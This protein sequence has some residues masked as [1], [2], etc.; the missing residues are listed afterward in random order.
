MRKISIM[1]LLIGTFLFFSVPIASESFYQDPETSQDLLDEI[2]K[3]C[4]EYCEKLTQSVLDFVCRESITEEISTVDYRQREITGDSAGKTSIMSS[5]WKKGN[6]LNTFIYDYQMI[7]KDNII[8]DRR[9]LIRENGIKKYEVNAEPRIKRFKHHNILFGPIALL[10]L[11]WQPFYDYKIIQ[12]EKFRREN[13]VVIEAIPK[14]TNT[15]ENPFGKGWVR[16]DDYSIIKIEW[17]QKSLPNLG[18][19]EKD[20]KNFRARPE[21]KFNVEY[22]LEK[23]GIR[24]PSKYSVVEIYYRGESVFFIRS[25]LDTT[26]NRYKFFTVETEVEYQHD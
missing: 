10:G 25:R 15:S 16:E 5:V 11:Q 14:D 13:V 12:K 24:F 21:I 19:F 1:M 22:G 9:I 23:N 6:E 2:L 4:A 17:D 8:T 26:Y 20:A 3:K 7:R 18:V